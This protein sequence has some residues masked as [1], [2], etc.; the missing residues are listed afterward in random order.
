MIQKGAVRKAIDEGKPSVDVQKLESE[1]MKVHTDVDIIRK[2]LRDY[3]HL[4]QIILMER[5]D[6]IAEEEYFNL[7]YPNGQPIEIKDIDRW[8]LNLVDNMYGAMV[9]LK[10]T[11]LARND[12]NELFINFCNF[13]NRDGFNTDILNE[14]ILDNINA[15]IEKYEKEPFLKWNYNLKTKSRNNFAE[16]PKRTWNKIKMAASLPSEIK[17]EQFSN[18]YGENWSH[19]LPKMKIDEYNEFTKH[20]N[21]SERLN[22][23]KFEGDILNEEVIKRCIKSKGN[24]SA[25]GLVRLTYPIFKYCPDKAAKLFKYILKMMLRTNKC[26]QC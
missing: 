5:G 21:K 12:L 19:S 25:P 4:Q 24:L 20:M 13:N 14:E 17:T 3:N 15:A 26:P 8:K 22:L 23:G 11:Q 10:T 18:H 6:R 2:F 16:D 1:I 9:K 7:V